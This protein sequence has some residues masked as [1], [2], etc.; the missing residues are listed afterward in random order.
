MM[1]RQSMKVKFVTGAVA[2]TSK[3]PLPL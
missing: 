2:V 1:I 3:T